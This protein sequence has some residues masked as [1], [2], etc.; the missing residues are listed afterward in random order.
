MTQM[1]AVN[2]TPGNTLLIYC[3]LWGL[4]LLLRSVTMYF[5]D[6]TIVGGSKDDAPGLMVITSGQVAAPVG[7]K[8]IACNM[9]V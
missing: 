8:S 6:G 9:L 5:A 2:Y 4:Q 3:T 7:V 1:Q